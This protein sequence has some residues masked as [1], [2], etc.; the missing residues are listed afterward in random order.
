MECVSARRG[1]GVRGG[2]RA[3]GRAAR[4][5][6]RRFARAFGPLPTMGLYSAGGQRCPPVSRR[7]RGGVCVT[8][9]MRCAHAVNLYALRFTVLFCDESVCQIK[10]RRS[11]AGRHLS[12]AFLDLCD[13]PPPGFTCLLLG[14]VEKTRNGCNKASGL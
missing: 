9:N 4:G 13:A 7:R 1:G 10:T 6:A 12:V 5:D 14:E 2:G 3:G 8:T 11:E